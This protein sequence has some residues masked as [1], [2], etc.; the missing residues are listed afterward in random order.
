MY[1]FVLFLFLC[2]YRFNYIKRNNINVKMCC[3]FNK[4]LEGLNINRIISEK[5]FI[6]WG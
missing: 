4:V 2:S 3:I 5:S 6:E 1:D